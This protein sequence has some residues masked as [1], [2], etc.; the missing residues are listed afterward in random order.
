MDEE[1]DLSTETRSL[2]DDTDEVLPML[3][4]STEGS[5]VVARPEVPV[6]V[7]AGTI[8]SSSSTLEVLVR[9]SIICFYMIS[10]QIIGAVLMER[11][12]TSSPSCALSDICED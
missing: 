3:A 7:I 4:T 9:L 8:T 5:T 1:M 11:I 10:L 6:E 2:L 12:R